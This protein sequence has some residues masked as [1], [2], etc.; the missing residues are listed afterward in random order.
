M[1]D[2]GFEPVTSSVSGKRATAAPIARFRDQD[3]RVS[4]E[5][6]TGFEPVWTALQAAASPLGQSTVRDYSHLLSAVRQ[7]HTRADDEIRTRDPNLGKVMR[8]HCA[9]SACILSNAL[10]TLAGHSRERK[11]TRAKVDR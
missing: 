9:T 1:G 7:D 10:T 3:P 4:V 2:T 6:D 5:V 8:Y 11:T